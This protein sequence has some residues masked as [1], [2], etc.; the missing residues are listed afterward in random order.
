LPYLTPIERLYVALRH[1]VSNTEDYDEYLRFISSPH[2]YLL[3]IESAEIKRIIYI[4][5]NS[6]GFNEDINPTEDA[7]KTDGDFNLI[8]NLSDS[9]D[10]NPE[11]KNNSLSVKIE[12]KKANNCIYLNNIWEF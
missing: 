8:D 1:T 4:R 5:G 9:T 3:N 6:E 11:L 7:P 12:F 2:T 10:E